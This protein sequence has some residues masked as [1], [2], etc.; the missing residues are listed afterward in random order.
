M[1]LDKEYGVM[2]RVI[3]NLRKRMSYEIRFRRI[4]NKK[5]YGGV[6]LNVIFRKKRVLFWRGG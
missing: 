6:R 5:E 1:F 4:W 2:G 3:K